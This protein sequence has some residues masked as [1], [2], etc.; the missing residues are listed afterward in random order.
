MICG[1]EKKGIGVNEDFVIL[2]IKWFKKNV[3]R[4]AEG[5]RLVVCREDYP[6]YV[7]SRKRF[8]SRQR[9]YLALGMAFAVLSMLVHPAVTTLAIVLAVVLLMYA[10]SLLSYTPKINVTSSHR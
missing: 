8:E 6:K 7:E 10:L 2:A 9:T 1:R 3:T 4:N 5:N